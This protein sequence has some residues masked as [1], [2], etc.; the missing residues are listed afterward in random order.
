MIEMSALVLICFTLSFDKPRSNVLFKFSI[1]LFGPSPQDVSLL[2]HR[3]LAQLQERMSRHIC[4]REYISTAPTERAHSPLPDF[5]DQMSLMTRV[6]G[7]YG[8]HANPSSTRCSRIGCSIA[9]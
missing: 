4:I 6:Y 7:R 5:I 2:P 1:H 3:E 8:T 9:N